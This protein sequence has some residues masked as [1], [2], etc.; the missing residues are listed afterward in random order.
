M[1][2]PYDGGEL[3]IT[4]IDVRSDPH[5]M[6]KA[7]SELMDRT[8]AF[9]YRFTTVSFDMSIRCIPDINDTDCNLKSEFTVQLVV[10]GVEDLTFPSSN[11]L[12]PT[13]K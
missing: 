12:S 1:N 8:P 11:N 3:V 7:Y 9:K 5:R 13:L 4:N 10:Q 6:E 2:A